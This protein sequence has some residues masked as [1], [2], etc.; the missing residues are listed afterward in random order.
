MNGQCI[1]KS[2]MCDCNAYAAD[3]V[4]STTCML[5][6]DFGSCQGFR[7]C[8]KYGLT[9]C[10]ARIPSLEVCDGLDNDCDGETDEAGC[11]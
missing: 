3:V 5:S 9:E 11:D 6:N 1:S 4:A 8:S 7:A 10:D 2:G